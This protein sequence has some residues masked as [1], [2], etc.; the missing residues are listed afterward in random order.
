MSCAFNRLRSLGRLL[1]CVVRSDGQ[2]LVNHSH[3]TAQHELS[4]VRPFPASLTVLGLYMSCDIGRAKFH[5]HFGMQGP[6]MIAGAA[7]CSQLLH[8]RLLSGS[9]ASSSGSAREAGDSFVS[10]NNLAD[11]PGARKKVLPIFVHAI[12]TISECGALPD[13][14][15]LVLSHVR[16]SI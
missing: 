16:L 13:Y 8:T 15:C 4:Q 7:T 2:S 10:L 3:I 1:S 6:R 11:N 12:C 14:M 9:F 5:A